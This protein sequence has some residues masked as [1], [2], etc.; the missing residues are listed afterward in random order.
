MNNESCLK[1]SSV[2]TLGIQFLCGWAALPGEVVT[3]VRERGVAE[4]CL[5][6]CVYKWVTVWRPESNPQYLP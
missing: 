5:Q 4:L 6:A 1:E 2:T 3:V